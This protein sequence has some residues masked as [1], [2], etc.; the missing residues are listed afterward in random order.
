MRK[1]FCF[2]WLGLFSLICWGQNN[3]NYNN[4]SFMPYD[5]Y[6]YNS[7]NTFHTSVKPYDLK[8]VNTIVSIDTLYEKHSKNN[9]TNYML[10]KDIIRYQSEN[11]NFTI[12]PAFNFEISRHNGKDSEKTGWINDRG[13]LINGNI[14]NKVYFHTAFH[15]IQSDYSDYRRNIMKEVGIVPGICYARKLGDGTILDYAY[16]EG[17]VSYIPNKNLALQLGHGKNF[18]GDGYRS[19]FLSDNTQNYPHCKITTNIGSFKYTLLW[20]QQ[21]YIQQNLQSFVRYSIKWSTIHYLDWIVSPHFSIG[22]FEA[23]MTG[24]DSTNTNNFNIHYLNPLPIVIP[25][26]NAEGYT[27]NCIVGINGKITLWENNI[28]YS[29]FALNTNGCKGN[30]LFKRNGYW[31]NRYAFQIGYKTYDVAQIRHL[32]FQSEFNFIRPFVYA[33]E[34]RSEAYNHATQPLAHPRGANLYESV[35][36]LQYNWRRL[37]VE[38]KYEYL[39]YGKDTAKTNMGGAVSK[40]VT[41]RLRDYDN[42]TTHSGNRNIVTYSDL[43]VSYLLNPK[44]TM[45]ITFGISHR[46]Q[47]AE[48]EESKNQW[49]YYIGFRTNLQNF[50]YDL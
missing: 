8:E 39:V 37:F 10:N 32:D 33:H 23:I 36:F 16:S 4:H 9:F 2:G 28:I 35:S 50:Y 15:E 14:T 49:L 18:I 29:Q 6:L 24:S 42:L 48:L 1:L 43:T 20:N 11:F 40:T 19:L 21:H 25:Q 31:G 27:D 26:K 12:N 3:S 22:L 7:S 45:N 34:T 17:Y 46:R 44:S 47:S 41:T 13:I 5:R 38:M 30:E